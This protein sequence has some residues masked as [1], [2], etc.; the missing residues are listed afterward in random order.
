MNGTVRIFMAPRNNEINRRHNM[1]QQRK[2]FFEMDKFSHS[3]NSNFELF[4]INYISTEH[5]KIAHV[6][7]RFTHYTIYCMQ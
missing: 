4:L 1:A 6:I 2:L 7:L 3:R 5:R